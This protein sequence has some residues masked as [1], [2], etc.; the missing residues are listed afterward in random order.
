[1]VGLPCPGRTVTGAQ[2]AG[3]A[4]KLDDQP[5]KPGKSRELFS[6]K[7]NLYNREFLFL[8]EKYEKK[9]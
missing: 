3:K 2:Q 7:F 6:V 1:L 9:S 5:G 8:E 4:G